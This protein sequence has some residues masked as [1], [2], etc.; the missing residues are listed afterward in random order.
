MNPNI[1]TQWAEEAED[2]LAA[3][4]R[5]ELRAIPMAEV[6]SK[7]ALHPASD[8]LRR[9]LNEWNEQPRYS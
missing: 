8:P 6:L 2:R 3:Y 4:R 9:T 1:T 7:Y 5:G